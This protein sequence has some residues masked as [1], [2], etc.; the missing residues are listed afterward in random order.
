[1]GQGAGA[2]AC[3]ALGGVYDGEPVDRAGVDPSDPFAAETPF[4][5]KKSGAFLSYGDTRLGQGREHA[6]EFL[7]NNAESAGQID[8]EIRRQTRTCGRCQ[9]EMPAVDAYVSPLELADPLVL[10]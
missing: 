7:K 1:V 2:A 8:G 3:C 9:P 5:V 4:L 6:R 10:T